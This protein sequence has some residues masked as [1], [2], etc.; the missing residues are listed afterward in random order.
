MSKTDLNN[1][2]KKYDVDKKAFIFII[3]IFYISKVIPV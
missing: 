3:N 2:L 1:R